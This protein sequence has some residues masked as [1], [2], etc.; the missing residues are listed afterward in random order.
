MATNTEVR[1][2]QKSELYDLLMLKKEIEKDS[3][4]YKALIRLINKK[5]AAME[6]EDVAY[7]E[8]KI[9]ELDNN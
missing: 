3:A 8:K 4:G 2:A 1:T 9:A 7:V 5:E 6:A